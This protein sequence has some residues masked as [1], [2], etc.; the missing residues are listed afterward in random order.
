MRTA[1]VFISI[2]PA[3][4]AKV[5]RPECKALSPKPDLQHQRQQERQRAEPHAEQKA[6]D[7]G[8]RIG[9]DLEQRQIDD[10]MRDAVGVAHIERDAD[11]AGDQQRRHRDT[12][13]APRPTFSNPKAR[14]A[15]PIPVKAKPARSNGRR[16]VSFK[17]PTKRL[18]STI[19]R[20]PIGILM[21]KIQR[22]DA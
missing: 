5:S 22:H 4:L 2:A 19:P 10:R 9:R 17:S 12:G 20:T 1:E 8:R 6:A 14:L 21:K 7:R 15:R 18:T 3:A 11:R 16:P 13:N